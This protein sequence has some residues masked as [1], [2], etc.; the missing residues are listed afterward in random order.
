MV[1][2]YNTYE[3]GGT[4][5]RI[6]NAKNLI[7]PNVN[8]I[9]R[10]VSLQGQDAQSKINELFSSAGNFKDVVEDILV[11]HTRYYFHFDNKL[12][13]CIELGCV[14]AWRN[15]EKT[16]YELHFIVVY[17]TNNTYYTS[18]VSVIYST[19]INNTKYHVANLV[20]SD[21]VSSN[22]VLDKNRD[23]RKSVSLI[24]EEF[25]E[26]HW[27]P[28]S[29]TAD[30]NSIVPPCNL[31]IWNSLNNDSAGISPK[32]SWATNN[33][34]FVLHIDMTI[35]GDGYGQYTYA[36]NKLNNWHGEWG[37]ETAV[38]EMRQTA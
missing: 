26:N 14:N 20:K 24:G 18:S 3:I 2:I 16:S 37:G 31:I 25:D 33:G 29:F 6:T 8:T 30:P 11:N 19:D 17:N 5:V 35:I 38:G 32:P 36:R 9:L 22:Y 10:P 12:T 27:Y 21:N 7:I 15:D 13:N 1:Y 4:E 23:N 34:G 28:V